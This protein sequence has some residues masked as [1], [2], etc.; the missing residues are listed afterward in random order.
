MRNNLN[1]HAA[2]VCVRGG[3]RQKHLAGGQLGGAPA[4]P[5]LCLWGVQSMGSRSPQGERELGDVWQWK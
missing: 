4:P 2:S 5:F 3:Q 1:P